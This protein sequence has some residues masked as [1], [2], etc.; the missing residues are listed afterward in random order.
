MNEK[1]TK[2]FDLTKDREYFI[3]TK[4]G[5]NLLIIKNERARILDADCPNKICVDKGYISKN[6][7]SIICLPHKVVVTIES[8]ENKDVDAVA[9]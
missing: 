3:D 8:S 2:T 7:E 5:Y 9:D 4:I 1:L 6:G